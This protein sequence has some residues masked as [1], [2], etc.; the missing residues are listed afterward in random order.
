[1]TYGDADVAV[2]AIDDP[3]DPRVTDYVGLS[4]ADARRRVEGTSWDDGPDGGFGFFVAEGALVIGHLVRSPYRVRSFLVTDR[5]LRA[6]EPVLRDRGPSAVGAPV[7]LATQSVMEAVAGFNFHRGALAA[8]DRRA[9]PDPADLAAGARRILLVEGV[10]DH[11][12]LGALFRNAAA[13]GVDAVLLDPTTCDP[14]YRRAVR[15]SAG[16]VLRLPFARLPDWPEG[17]FA[18]LRAEG[19]EVVALT[20]SPSADDVRDL[21][22]EA[23]PRRRALLVGAEGAGLSAASLAAAD[24]RVRIA[25]APGVDSLNVATAAAIALHQWHLASID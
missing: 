18:A 21:R 20:P 7:Y 14:L 2:E 10:G 11:E 15:V 5:G 8:A 12:N 13:F 6:L 1:M 22:P 17:A 24:R 16:H 19:Y 4:D 9:L 23:A 25:M 3:A